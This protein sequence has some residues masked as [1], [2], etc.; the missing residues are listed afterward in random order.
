MKARSPHIDEQHLFDYFP[1]IITERYSHYI[2]Q[3]PLK[4]QI[5]ANSLAH[6]MIHQQKFW[7]SVDFMMGD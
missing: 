2:L 3:H 4:Q 1:T 6:D 5:M 7:E